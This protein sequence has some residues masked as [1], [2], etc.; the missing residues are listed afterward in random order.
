MALGN[1]LTEV[2]R[3][4]GVDLT[5]T[6]ERNI[7][8]DEVNK[9]AREIYRRSDLP[10]VLQE[11]YVRATPNKELALPPF[12][13][14]IRAIRQGCKD[15][16]TDKWELHSMYPRYNKDEWINQWKNWRVKGSV[17][18]GIEWTETAPGT[19]TYPVIDNDLVISL[20]GE[21]ANSNRAIDQI[22]VS[23]TS[24]NWTK[25]F[26][27]IT[28]VAKNKITDYN[29][30]LTDAAGDECAIIYADQ[31]ESQYRVVDVSEYPETL[32]GCCSCSDGTS[33]MEV[34]YKPI[35]PYMYNDD[36]FFPVPG[37]DDAIIVK[38]LQ[39][40][41]EDEEGKEQRAILM[42]A[43]AERLVKEITGDKEGHIKRKMN[44]KRNPF[45][46][47]NYRNKRCW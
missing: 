13:G 38:T 31:L 47:N 42:D 23:A 44:T 12:V 25:T 20:V 41:T 36:D 8:I 21:T 34:L 10:V 22:T 15:Y 33:I 17:P 32:L 16:C 3:K 4:S 26:L 28:R 29:V 30:V 39:L 6:G 7:L 5:D 45:F 43:K 35:L 2:A 46:K 19:I 9:A 18:I 37:F 24:V 1:I 27:N 14:E 40:L 11:V